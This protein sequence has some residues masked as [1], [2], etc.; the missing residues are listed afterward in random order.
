MSRLDVV[1]AFVC[2]DVMQNVLRYSFSRLNFDKQPVCLLSLNRH[3]YEDFVK[4][5]K[6][7]SYSIEHALS[8]LFP[9]NDAYGYAVIEYVGSRMSEPKMSV[10]TCKVKDLSYVAGLYITVRL[11]LFD[12]NVEAKTRSVKMIK[13]Q[14]LYLCDIP[15]MLSKIF[16]QLNGIIVSDFGH[17]CGAVD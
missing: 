8:S 1:N 15:L 2:V 7:C 6:S 13:E 12:V 14:E 17:I 9:I 3:S 11:I 4:G 16:C 5:G 10:D